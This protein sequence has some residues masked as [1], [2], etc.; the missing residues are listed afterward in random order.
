[1]Y[2]VAKPMVLSL[3]PKAKSSG[4]FHRSSTAV[5]TRDT[6]S[7]KPKQLPRVFSAES[8]SCRPIK[9][10]ARGAP[11]APTNAAKADTI[12]ISG[13]QTPTP[14]SARLPFSGIWPM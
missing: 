6:A 1:M 4:L 10:E 14:V 13:M 11:P 12:M 7:C 5:S 3:A 9:M 2:S 8:M